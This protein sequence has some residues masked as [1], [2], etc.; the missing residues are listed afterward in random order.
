LTSIGKAIVLL[1]RSFSKEW[2]KIECEGKS[3]LFPA[4]YLKIPASMAT[5]PPQQ[6]VPISA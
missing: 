6:P 5:P 1:D 3:G 4:G 2:F